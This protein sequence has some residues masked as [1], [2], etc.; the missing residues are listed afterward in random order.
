M[1]R[2]RRRLDRDGVSDPQDAAT[3]HAQVDAEVGAVLRVV[4]AEQRRHVDVRAAAAV[5]RVDVD[6]R[7]PDRTREDL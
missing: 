3:H 5:P 7:A 6:G 1:V 2:E 4:A